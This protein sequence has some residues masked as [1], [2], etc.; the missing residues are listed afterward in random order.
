MQAVSGD[1]AALDISRG[2]DP[3][4][5]RWLNGFPP[6]IFGDRLYQSIELMERYSIAL[7]ARVLDE[8]GIREQ[9]GEWHTSQQL[10]AHLSFQP[11][12]A[13]ALSWLLERVL[14]SDSIEV[15]RDGENPMYRARGTGCK[16]DL[17]ELRSIALQ[18]DSGNAAT[19]DLLD[20]AAAN[21]ATIA[22]G[23][24]TAE[25]C[26]FGPNGIALW[27]TYF[28]NKNLTYSVNN[29]VG[30]VVAAERL[31]S[32]PRIRILEVGAGAGSASTTL[33][34]WFDRQDLL[35][36]IEHYV[37]TEPNAFFRRRAQ[38]EVTARYPTV[39]LTWSSLNVNDPWSAQI[40]D[41]GDFDLVYAV[42]VLHVSKNLLFSLKEAASALAPNG[43]LVLGE[44]IR[45][46]DN[47]PIYPELMFQN[48]DSFTD[49]LVDPEIRPR[50]GFLTAEQW[51][52]AFGRAGLGHVE[53]APDIDSIQTIY[54]H[55]FTAAIC[56][57][58]SGANDS[59]DGR[60]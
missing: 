12:F 53:V 24:D 35:P 54:S 42:N 34:E 25:G 9:L 14:G 43:W 48:L 20:H 44:C 30:A 23:E 16:I 10:C 38:R 39:P 59:T 6:E 32:R 17:A 19:L 36:R 2:G 27:L 58:Q 47:Q 33:L 60:G 49:V 3:G 51:R 4:L 37:A 46:H 13:A 26:M 55:F 29:W 8:L 18:I 57:Q 7:S 52:R 31:A 15:K 45:P 5:G 40:A 56:G 28:H 50:A 41:R 1:A 22:R 11:R 21:Y